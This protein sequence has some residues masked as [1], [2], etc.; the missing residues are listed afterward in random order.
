MRKWFTK[1]GRNIDLLRS[2]LEVENLGH[3]KQSV[4]QPVAQ[5][6]VIYPCT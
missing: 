1:R 4:G 6:H 3:Y 2:P 5:T